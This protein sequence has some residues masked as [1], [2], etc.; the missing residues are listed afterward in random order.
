MLSVYDEEEYAKKM[1]KNGF[2]SPK[3]RFELKILAKYYFFIEKLPKKR[4]KPLLIAF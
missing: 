4:I 3:I 1:L 2:L